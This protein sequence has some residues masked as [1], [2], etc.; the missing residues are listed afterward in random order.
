[1]HCFVHPHVSP[2]FSRIPLGELTAKFI[3]VLISA[4]NS[5]IVRLY[6]IYLRLVCVRLPLRPYRSARYVPDKGL[7]THSILSKFR[8]STVTFSYDRIP[9][10]FSITLKANLAGY[11][12]HSRMS[13]LATPSQ[14]PPYP[15]V[16]QQ[17]HPHRSSWCSLFP[18]AFSHRLSH[19]H[20]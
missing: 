17:Q 16:C 11:R 7:P 3:D 12:A 8:G 1:M 6:F 10:L 9:L 14:Q 19:L 13:I 20:I 2:P 4:L 18:E 5:A 15:A